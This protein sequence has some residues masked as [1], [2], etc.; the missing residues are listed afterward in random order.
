[1]FSAVHAA[2][3][4]GST[5]MIT[6][7]H[8]T[9]LRCL[10]IASAAG[11]TAKTVRGI[12]RWFRDNPAHKR[13]LFRLPRPQSAIQWK[14]A[15]KLRKSDPDAKRAIHDKEFRR[16]YLAGLKRREARAVA[17]DGSLDGVMKYYLPDTR[18]RRR[19]E[20]AECARLRDIVTGKKSEPIPSPKFGVTLQVDATT[21][22]RH[23]AQLCLRGKDASILPTKSPS[24]VV[25]SDGETEWKGGKPKK[26]TRATNDNYVRSLAVIRDRQTLDYVCHETR[27][28][29]TLPE[30]VFWN[31]D[32]N[33]LRAVLSNSDRDDFHPSAADVVRLDAAAH[34]VATIG[35]NRETRLHYAALEAAEAAQVDGVFVCL[36]D[37]LRAG[38]CKAGTLHFAQ[39]HNLDPSR[40][41][42][43]PVLLEQANG[44]AGRVRLAITA[45]RIRHERETA[46]GFC[47]LAEHTVSSN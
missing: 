4:K 22:R 1:M 21:A 37:S 15:E 10:A 38:N 24:H 26:Y 3:L 16:R 45:A 14:H 33:G 13:D 47:D 44:D 29:V 23:K 19:A 2:A 25:H 35:R 31:I 39:R 41:Y 43:A 34:I 40:H 9:F 32:A 20:L 42:A 7:K 28:T 11:S 17:C 18:A 5:A 46:N 30:G 36:A 6:V 8:P 12:A 27:Y